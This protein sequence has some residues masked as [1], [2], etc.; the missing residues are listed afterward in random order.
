MNT[1]NSTEIYKEEWIKLYNEG[2]SY[3]EI[4]NMYGYAMSSVKNRI[5]DFVVKRDKFA[6]DKYA[7][8]W[9]ELNGKGYTTSQIAEVYG[10]S[11]HVVYRVLKKFGYVSS[12][13]SKGKYK[14][15][16][17]DMVR[18]Y[19]E[20]KS[21]KEIADLFNLSKQ[22]VLEYI[23]A[24]NQNIIRSYSESIRRYS[25][26]DEYF[27]NIDSKKAFVLGLMIKTSF[28]VNKTG[29]YSLKMGFPKKKE[30]IV[31][32]IFAQMNYENTNYNYNEKEDFYRP[33]IG[34]LK[35]TQ[36]MKTIGF[37]EA[38]HEYTVLN[39]DKK[40]KN[41]FINGYIFTNIVEYKNTIN[42]ECIKYCDSIE[43][44][45]WLSHIG[46]TDDLVTMT[47]G[48][49]FIVVE[50]ERSEKKIFDALKNIEKKYGLN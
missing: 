3:R 27:D 31:K 45:K 47:Y 10:V 38:N 21:L 11:K 14:H 34:C 22:T 9:G 6:N 23:K 12:S 29:R 24:D 15:L 37:R 16:Q 25:I 35:L 1:K 13:L 7:D 2:M 8:I 18:L 39:I 33:E 19:K 43:I 50:K 32:Y 48:E 30:D 20:G 17:G 41:D 4:G 40:Y 42:I 5:S 46:V 26:D 28:L 49:K 44:K 36:Q